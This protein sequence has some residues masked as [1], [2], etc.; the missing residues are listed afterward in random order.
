[1]KL[2]DF[3]IVL[4]DSTPWASRK[5]CF[6]Y[7]L[8][9]VKIVIFHDFDYFPVNNIIGHVVS[10]ETYDGKVKITCDLDNVVKNYKL[11]Y[12]PYRFLLVLLH[13]QR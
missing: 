5:L 6:D 3:E 10:S 12:P 1:M 8:N 7:F 13:H 2:N 11:L 4:I 9:K